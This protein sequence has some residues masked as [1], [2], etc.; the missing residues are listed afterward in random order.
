MSTVI[1]SLIAMATL[2][3]A[4][5]LPETGRP[6][7]QKD[8]PAEVQG[9]ANA[10]QPPAEQ[11]NDI[12][13]TATRSGPS[14][15]VTYN[16]QAATS[17]ATVTVADALNR[18]PSVSVDPDGK[19][20]LRGQEDVTILIDGKLA[21]SLQGDE[22]AVAL[23]SMSADQLERVEVY[24]TPP[25]QFTS[26][27]GGGVINLVT[28]KTRDTRPK[29]SALAAVGSSRRYKVSLSGSGQ[30]SGARVEGNAGY[31][32]DYP[33]SINGTD[34]ITTN[35][36]TGETTRLT[37]AR[38]NRCAQ[39]RWDLGG[40]ASA[41]LSSIDT[42]TLGGTMWG[43]R[44]DCQSDARQQQF[45][46]SGITLLDLM[47]T[48]LRSYDRRY[49]AEATARYA[50]NGK[51]DSL[52]LNASIG[53][54]SFDGFDFVLNQFSV[55]VRSDYIDYLIERRDNRFLTLGTDY[56]RKA[57]RLNFAMG[58]QLERLDQAYENSAFLIDPDTDVRTENGDFVSS[59][60]YK[61]AILGLYAKSDLR[62]GGVLLGVGVRYEH[63]RQ[64]IG[65]R[66]WMSQGPDRLNPSFSAA[67][68]TRSGANVRFDYARR[69]QRPVPTDL[70][71]AI[72]FGNLFNLY[73]GNPDLKP[74]VIDLLELGLSK[75][76]GG[77]QF[78]GKLFYRDTA[79]YI[80]DRLDLI[81]SSVL[82][83]TKVNSGSAKSYGLDVS[84]KHAIAQGFSV[85]L[86]SVLAIMQ[87]NY[88]GLFGDPQQDRIFA[89]SVKVGADYR[90][91]DD[92]QIQANFEA[93]NRILTGQGIKGSLLTTNLSYQRRLSSRI[94]ANVTFNNPFRWQNVKTR[95]KNELVQ[96]IGDRRVR[97][98][99]VFLVFRFGLGATKVAGSDADL[100]APVR[101]F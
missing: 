56:Q 42:I 15:R 38:N 60:A 27:G 23:Q 21:T 50:H 28:R 66:S 51:K 95:T 29:G 4:P 5:P 40:S 3:D 1:V 101:N 85:S 45:A 31:R 37:I 98:S 8:T 96:E 97:D 92:D 52:S 99:S 62:L 24:T 22:Q 25:V 49:D 87:V 36:D 7:P 18:V 33:G 16:V 14:D 6:L 71:P 61:R 78:S 84:G 89:P 63:A 17:N 69:I 94:A 64:K 82:L 41:D 68:K 43:R 73:Q 81:E 9:S 34:R 46:Q 88:T 77:Q 79:G 2:S 44:G 19:V 47:R 58:G 35:P 76:G 30:L 26:N 11:P 59:F 13:V 100:A 12:V 55:P 86:S 93:S 57:G 91:T 75:E 80:V 83:A 90:V 20:A 54:T 65:E 10:Q 39:K 70:N 53:K 67:L 48:A 72:I 74:E 32:R